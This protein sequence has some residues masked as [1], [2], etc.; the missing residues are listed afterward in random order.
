M[1]GSKRMRVQMQMH[2]Q[3]HW[4]RETFVRRLCCNRGGRGWRE[5]VNVLGDPAGG[6]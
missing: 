6:R 1:A 2:L 3:S 5:R 4:Q